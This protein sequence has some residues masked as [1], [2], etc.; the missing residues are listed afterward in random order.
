[1][2]RFAAPLFLLS[3]VPQSRAVGDYLLFPDGPMAVTMR[4]SSR[5]P[6]GGRLAAAGSGPDTQ[7]PGPA[8]K[9]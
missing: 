5:A 1:M 2:K 3:G 6:I 9:R 4:V 8:N 7:G